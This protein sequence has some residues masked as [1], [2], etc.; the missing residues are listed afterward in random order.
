MIQFKRLT[1]KSTTNIDNVTLK[2]GQPAIDLKNKTLYVGSTETTDESTSKLKFYDSGHVDN[3]L[4]NKVTVKNSNTESYIYPTTGNIT[5]I[6]GS[7]VTLTSDT[8]NKTVTIASSYTDTKVTSA[9]NHYSPTTDSASQ[10]SV[11]AS[12]TTSATWDSTSIIT[13]VNL[14]RDTKG[15]VTGITVDSVKMPANPDTNQKVKAKNASGTYITFGDNDVVE[16]VAGSNVTITPD[17]I[18]KKITINSQYTNTSHYHQA[19]VGLVGSGDDYTTSGTYTYKAALK[20]ETKDTNAA[21]SRPNANASRTYPVIVDKEGKLATIVPWTD[22]VYT[23]PTASNNTLGGIKI[24]TNGGI[25]YRNGVIYPYALC[26][27]NN[28]SHNELV[29]ATSEGVDSS[30][31]GGLRAKNKLTMLGTPRYPWHKLYATDIY[32][33]GTSQWDSGISDSNYTSLNGAISSI[34]SRLNSLGFN[35]GS[36]VTIRGIGSG[37]FTLTIYKLGK[38]VWCNQSISSV[39]YIYNK[40]KSTTYL[41]SDLRP[42]SNAVGAILGYNVKS[43]PYTAGYSSQITIDTDGFIT[44]EVNNDISVSSSTGYFMNYICFAYKLD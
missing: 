37:E 13:G 34:N 8:V 3:K 25:T 26:D 2:S 20:D 10:L 28:A 33:N 11:N 38:V 32:I 39:S 12:S 6:Q 24:P 5:F 31:A 15:H 23:L 27:K 21:M 14:Q 30:Y 22:T 4:V 18:N 1:S 16:I 41:P 17:A 35:G 36:D 9:T 40:R 43:G 29:F 19:G 42:S 44:L 7:N